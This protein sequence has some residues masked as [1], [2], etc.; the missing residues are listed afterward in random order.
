M[1]LTKEAR[2]LLG[3]RYKEDSNTQGKT[4]ATG[5]IKNSQGV[6]VIPPSMVSPKTKHG[7]LVVDNDGLPIARETA[8]APQPEPQEEQAPAK[9]GRKRK[10]ATA[11]TPSKPQ[12]VRVDITMNGLGKIPAQYTRCCIGNDHAL[13]GLADVSFIPEQALSDGQGNYRNVLQLS[14]DPGV[15]YIFTGS[16]NNID[17]VRHILLWKIS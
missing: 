7:A 1:A 13:L 3:A 15:N 8:P 14:T 12:L 9:K 2:D 10:Q 16:T 17:G 5:M 4:T 6:L 11:E